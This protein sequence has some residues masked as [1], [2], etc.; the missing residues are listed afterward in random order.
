MTTPTHKPAK[1]LKP[2]F[3]VALAMV[4][5]R[6]HTEAEVRRKLRTK[7]YFSK[8]ISDVIATLQAKNYL[9][10]ER[11]ASMMVRRRAV[12]SKWGAGRIAQELAAK[13]I[14]KDLAKTRIAT[15][16]EGEEGIEGHDWQEAA[17]KLLRAKY[18]T[19]LPEDRNERQKERAKRLGFLQRR[20]FSAGQAY[21]AYEAAFGL[22]SLEEI[23]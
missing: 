21:K 8:E 19:P 1:P 3:E 22:G 10:D 13:G 17:T 7:G 14:E 11:A 23:E 15:F 5:R 4:A 9:N 20:G 16:T 6:E 2:I 12:G 18:K